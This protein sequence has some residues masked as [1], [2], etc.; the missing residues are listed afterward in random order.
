MT[1]II[2]FVRRRENTTGLLALIC[3]VSGC[4]IAVLA[5]CAIIAIAYRGGNISAEQLNLLT[6]VG[7]SGA[8]LFAF[9]GGLL[10]VNQQHG[11]AT[12]PAPG[13]VSVASTTTVETEPQG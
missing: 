6:I 5:A 11:R 2:D 4:L 7:G 3:G 10:A 12:D 8:G 13:A 1:R 9:A